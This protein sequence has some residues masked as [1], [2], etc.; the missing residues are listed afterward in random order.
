[1]KRELRSTE[2]NA[3]AKCKPLNLREA[4][5][6]QWN[7]THSSVWSDIVH[8]SWKPD[9]IRNSGQTGRTS[10]QKIQVETGTH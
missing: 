4:L 9:S 3:N 6:M 7:L 5:E 1:M 8:D 10:D 2:Q